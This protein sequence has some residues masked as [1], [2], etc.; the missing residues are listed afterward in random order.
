MNEQGTILEK[1]LQNT[2][3]MYYYHNIFI[4][5]YNLF[6]N[7]YKYCKSSLKRNIPS[8]CRSKTI[9]KCS[10]CC[11]YITLFR[12][13]CSSHFYIYIYIFVQPTNLQ[14]LTSTAAATTI[15]V[16]AAFVAGE[17]SDRKT[18]TKTSVKVLNCCLLLLLFFSF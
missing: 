18:L 7:D 3:L 4:Y 1:L 13:N 2:D 16:L 8:S 11:D 9:C 6:I 12:A 14:Q 17:Q 10:Y 5:Y 15:S